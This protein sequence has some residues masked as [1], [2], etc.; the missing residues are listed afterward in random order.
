MTQVTYQITDEKKFNN[1]V[2]DVDTG[3]LK[4][5]TTDVVKGAIGIEIDGEGWRDIS[6]IH[7]RSDYEEE[8]GFILVDK[9]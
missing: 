9:D 2:I 8:F 4:P 3:E 1:K 7:G 5:E 6:G